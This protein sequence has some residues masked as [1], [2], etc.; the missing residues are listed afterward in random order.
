MDKKEFDE[1]YKYLNAFAIYE[2]D[3]QEDAE[4]R[5]RFENELNHVSFEIAMENAKKVYRN[6]MTPCNVNRLNPKVFSGENP[7]PGLYGKAE[8]DFIM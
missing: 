4:I 6:F 1:F 3:E 8:A 7:N 2:T 5:E